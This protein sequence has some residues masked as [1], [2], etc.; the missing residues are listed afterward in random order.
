M[1]FRKGQFLKNIYMVGSPDEAFNAGSLWVFLRNAFES[2]A[3]QCYL[4]VRHCATNSVLTRHRSCFIELS[5]LEE[6]ALAN[7]P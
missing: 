7:E 3:N 2:D 1:L 4:L 5:P 6:L